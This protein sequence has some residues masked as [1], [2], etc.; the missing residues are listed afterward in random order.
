MPITYSFQSPPGVIV[1]AVTGTVSVAD[2]EA[3][4]RDVSAESWFPA[5]ALV[6]TREASANLPSRDVRA[7]VEL[8]RR[9]GSRLNGSPIAVVVPSDVAYGLVRMIELLLDEVVTIG[10]FRT[11]EEAIAWLAHQQ[12][13]TDGWSAV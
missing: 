4:I 13:S 6:D 8:L 7:I 2:V 9:L 10:A 1:T 11:R 5:P 3:H 12:R